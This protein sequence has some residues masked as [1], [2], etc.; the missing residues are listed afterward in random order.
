M[1]HRK[2]KHCFSEIWV[3]KHFLFSRALHACRSMFAH[4]HMQQDACSTCKRHQ[5]NKEGL[6]GLIHQRTVREV[7][8]LQMGVLTKE[9]RGLQLL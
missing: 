4:I 6:S 7:R 9:Y 3:H 5:H 2:M 1:P 8:S